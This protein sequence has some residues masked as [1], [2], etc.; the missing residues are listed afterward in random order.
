MADANFVT[1]W[2]GHYREVMEP[3]ALQSNLTRALEVVRAVKGR[4]SKLIF[5]GNGASATI[6]SHY[7]LD[8]TKQGGVRSMAF[9]DA[10]LITAYG[11]DYGYADWVARAVDHHGREGDAAILISTSGGSANIVNA[12]QL[13]RERGIT[14]LGFSGFAE[15]NKL[16]AVSDIR[17]WAESRAYNVVEAV[18]GMWLGVLCDLLIGQREYGVTG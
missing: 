5:A 15:D 4:D 9:N 7:A 6:A 3:A 10:A 16:N 8:F 17:F 1:D 11:N 14:V 13:C 2:L 12:A 18:H